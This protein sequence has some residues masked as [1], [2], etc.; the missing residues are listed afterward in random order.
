MNGAFFVPPRAGAEPV[1]LIEAE[2]PGPAGLRWCRLAVRAPHV[3]AAAARAAAALDAP[4]SPRKVCP[5][6]EATLDAESILLAQLSA[7]T[8]VAAGPLL[9]CAAA[10][11]PMTLPLQLAQAPMPAPGAQGIDTL[12][13]ALTDTL[14][15]GAND[16]M[17]LYAVFDG[18]RVFGLPERLETS[19]LSWR[20]LFQGDTAREHGAAAPYLVELMPGNTLTRRLLR[21]PAP[22]PANATATR[23]SWDEVPSTALDAAL[24]LTSPVT[25]DGLRRHLRR[26]TMVRDAQTGQQVFF[27]FF[28]PMV[29][30]TLVVNM[31]PEDQAALATGIHGLAARDPQGGFVMLIRRGAEV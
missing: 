4:V 6:S 29:F 3:Q 19:G 5:A 18:A 21:L 25:I 8:A 26:F 17:R 27:R 7:E 13:T 15:P 23:A 12:P 11:A 2:L 28:D 24:F 9:W 1:W 20:C 22:T 14:L 30:R 31:A 16:A 10:D